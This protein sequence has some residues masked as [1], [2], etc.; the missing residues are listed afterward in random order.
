MAEG[1]SSNG[2]Y[3][4]WPDY[5]K[6]DADERRRKLQLKYDEAKQRGDHPYAMALASAV[7]NYERVQEL[8]P[9]TQHEEPVASAA[10]DLHNDAGSWIGS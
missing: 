9:D 8:Q 10:R 3:E 5:A 1:I 7:A 4:P 6:L 2:A